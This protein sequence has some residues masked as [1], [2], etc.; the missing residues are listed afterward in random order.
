[1]N[2]VLHAEPLWKALHFHYYM[3]TSIIS[4]SFETDIHLGHAGVTQIGRFG[5]LCARWSLLSK[6][7][8][9]LSCSSCSSTTA[10]SDRSQP[11]FKIHSLTTPVF[12][13]YTLGM[14]MKWRK[15]VNIARTM[16]AAC[17]LPSWPEMKYIARWTIPVISSND[18]VK[19]V[20]WMLILTCRL[21]LCLAFSGRVSFKKSLFWD[22]KI[23]N[24]LEF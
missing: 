10:R 18:H 22:L 7:V 5:L 9:S 2:I 21:R 11:F 12:R 24:L 23:Y 1:M 3:L 13:L 4:R 8:S 15:C 20:I 16:F 14:M 6:S 17:R 19:K